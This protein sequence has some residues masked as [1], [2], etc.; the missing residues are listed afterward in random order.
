[1]G[2]RPRDS[3]HGDKAILLCDQDTHSQELHMREP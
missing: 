1:M 2:T 3:S